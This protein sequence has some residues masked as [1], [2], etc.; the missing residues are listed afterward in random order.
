MANRKVTAAASQ[1]SPM[2]RAPTAAMLTSRSMLI[3]RTASARTALRT[4]G[5]PATKAAATISHW[6][7]RAAP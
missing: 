7:A 2:T 6:A 4:M 5:A 3:W 1:Y